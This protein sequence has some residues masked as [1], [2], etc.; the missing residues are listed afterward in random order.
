MEQ[1]NIQTPLQKDA[2]ARAPLGLSS[3]HYVY[4]LVNKA[5]TKTYVGYTI[6]PMR[7]LRQHN[8]EL[9][10]GAKRTRNDSWEHVMIITAPQ[11]DKHMAL[12]L[13][14]HMKEHR[15]VKWNRLANPIEN[16]I[17][18]FERAKQLPKFKDCQWNVELKKT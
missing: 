5:R 17:A 6:D 7:R 11:L 15:Q 12:S 18:L 2:D 8:G 3:P 13:E 4:V 14:W 16:R 9:S 1:Q 10:G